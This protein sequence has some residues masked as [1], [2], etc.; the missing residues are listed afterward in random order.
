[1]ALES[2]RRSSSHRFTTHG[3]KKTCAA[4]TRGDVAPISDQW[5]SPHAGD[6]VHKFPFDV[7][8]F[9]GIQA[10]VDFRWVPYVGPFLRTFGSDDQGHALLRR[11]GTEELAT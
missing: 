9:G 6:A 11:F 3:P 5:R 10:G 1:M 8:D 2:A 4:S 7:A